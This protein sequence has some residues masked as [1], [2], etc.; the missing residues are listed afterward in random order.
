MVGCK[1]KKKRNVIANSDWSEWLWNTVSLLQVIARKGK[2]EGRAEAGRQDP[3]SKKKVR[4]RFQSGK[5]M[6]PGKCGF[7]LNQW[8]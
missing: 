4:S 3:E 1:P 2:K 8:K 6:K 5:R 7:K